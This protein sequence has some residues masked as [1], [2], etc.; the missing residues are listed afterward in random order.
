M[1]ELQLSRK[2]ESHGATVGILTG[3]GKTLYTLEEAWRGNKPKISCIPA[4]KYLCLPHGWEEG[5]KVSKPQTWEVTGVPGRSAVLI[6]IGNSTKDTEGC[7]LAGMGFQVSQVIAM[8]TD[9]RIAINYMRR[10]IGKNSFMIAI[11]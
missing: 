7:I 10:E 1:I 9:S 8:V 4:G 6:H 2:F 3:L 11:E 5:S